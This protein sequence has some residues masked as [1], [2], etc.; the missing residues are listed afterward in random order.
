MKRRIW[1]VSEYYYPI[2][3]STGF[4]MTEI[5]EF[6]SRKGMDV[7]VICTGAKYNETASYVM[8]KYEEHNGVIIHRVLA[9][10]IDKNDFIKRCLLYTSPSPRDRG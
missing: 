8:K 5:A 10:G 4:Y 1:I 9:L 6:L 7:H 3:T 2:V